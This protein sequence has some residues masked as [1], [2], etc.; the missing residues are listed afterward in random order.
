PYALAMAC[1]TGSASMMSAQLGSV[2]DANPGMA[3]QLTAYAAASNMLTGVDG[4]YMSLFI[5]LP[6]SNWLY[7]VFTKNNK[8]YKDGVPLPKE[9]KAKA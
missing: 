5:A 2:I 1:G 3:D 8:N 4:L 9:K 6:M 7:K